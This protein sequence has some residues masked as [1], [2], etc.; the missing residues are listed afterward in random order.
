MPRTRATSSALPT[1]AAG[2]CYLRHVMLIAGLA[3]TGG[4]ITAPS[5][6]L[7]SATSPPKVPACYSSV[8]A[9]EG[10]FLKAPIGAAKKTGALR[11]VFQLTGPAPLQTKTPVACGDAGCLY[12]HLNWVVGPGA[13]G[14]TGCEPNTTTCSVKIA[15]GSGSWVPVL[16]NQN[17]F[18]VALFLLWTPAGAHTISGKVTAKD[19]SDPAGCKTAPLGGVLVRAKGPHGSGSDVSSP[20]GRY[21]ISVARG[22]NYEVTPSSG[23]TTFSPERRKVDATHDVGGVDFV[24]EDTCPVGSL[25]TATAAQGSSCPRETKLTMF[26][27][28]RPKDFVSFTKITT[29]SCFVT[30]R[31]LGR[32][33]HQNPLGSVR[34]R[35]A[36]P[37]L[38]GIVDPNPCT[39]TAS[40]STGVTECEVTLGPGNNTKEGDTLAVDATYSP[41]DMNF[42]PST[43]AFS[44]KYTPTLDPTN[45]VTAARAEAHLLAV[46]GS[47]GA[48]AVAAPISA[49]VAG[50]TAAVAGLLAVPFHYLQ[51]PDEPPD[52]AYAQVFHPRFPRVG[53]ARASSKALSA[54][55]TALNRN[56]AAIEGWAGAEWNALNRSVIALQANDRAAFVTQLLAESRNEKMLAGLLAKLPAEMKAIARYS[57]ARYRKASAGVS[58]RRLATLVKR[59]RKNAAAQRRL[60]HTVGIPAAVAAGVITGSHPP[61]TRRSVNGN[62]AANLNALIAAEARLAVYLRRVSAIH[63]AKAQLYR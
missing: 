4:L 55:L 45:K 29:Q 39:L 49:P 52:P 34:F 33:P 62:A 59:A 16:V 35:S 46:V 12:N 17:D 9:C 19:C 6:A 53:R 57:P 22:K 10:I 43:V 28:Y 30:V 7:A 63:A 61:V 38:I 36:T 26:C 15:P 56:D 50:P 44:A 20:S 47:A 13:L 25:S 60:F 23:D 18:P 21:E 58:T 1:R 37:T 40:V 11:G 2:R 27:E 14:T 51:L 54:A 31:D 8:G 5:S 42:R 3:V 24:A 41:S 32:P 48:V